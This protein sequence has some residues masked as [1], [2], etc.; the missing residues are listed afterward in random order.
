MKG[1]VSIFRPQNG[2]T[3]NMVEFIV[4][5]YMKFISD[6]LKDFCVVNKIRIL[7]QKD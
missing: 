1:M 3:C 7:Q 4:H 5:K 2:Q 6:K